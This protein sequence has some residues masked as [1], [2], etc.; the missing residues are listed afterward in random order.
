MTLFNWIQIALFPLTLILAIMADKAHQKSN[1]R[2]EWKFGFM[3][4]CLV[5]F[6]TIVSFIDLTKG[7]ALANVSLPINLIILMFGSFYL[8]GLKSIINGENED[9]FGKP[10]FYV[11][12]YRS[13]RGEDKKQNSLS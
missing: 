6:F 4:I 10:A 13:I 12:I 8:A 7:N 2:R 3:A 9:S 11:W 1:L 5:C